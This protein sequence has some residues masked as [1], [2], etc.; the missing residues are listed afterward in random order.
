MCK[1]VIFLTCMFITSTMFDQADRDIISN[2]FHIMKK[3]KNYNYAHSLGPV[4][5]K[6]YTSKVNSKP[7]PL[8][9]VAFRKTEEPELLEVERREGFALLTYVTGS[10]P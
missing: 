4:Q 8:L 5:L 3:K 9:S 10:G 7:Q 2:K 6:G 1:V